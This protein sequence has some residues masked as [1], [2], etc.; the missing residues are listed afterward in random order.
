VR[1]VSDATVDGSGTWQTSGSGRFH[2]DLVVSRPGAA[3][4]HVTV[5]WNQRVS[6]ALA[7]VGGA[8]LTLPAP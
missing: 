5:D 8:S 6:T 3:P 7:T 2:G 1:F 4:V